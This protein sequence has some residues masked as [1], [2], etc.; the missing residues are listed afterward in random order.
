[1][2]TKLFAFDLF[3]T[4]FDMRTAHPVDLEDYGDHL[5]DFRQ[6]GVW[7]PLVLPSSWDKLPAYPDSEPAIA[8]LRDKYLC[9]ALS[10]ASHGMR[11]FPSKPPRR[12]SRTTMPT[13][14]CFN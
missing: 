2:A 4:V 1:M 6:T 8:E 11:S 5:S 3:G 13:A 9:V 10:N 7:K 12:S 14:T